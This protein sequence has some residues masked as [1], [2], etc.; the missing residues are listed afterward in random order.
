MPDIGPT[1]ASSRSSAR[2]ALADH[3]SQAE[4][5]A[6]SAA[7][8]AGEA[9]GCAMSDAVVGLVGALVG[10][11]AAVGGAVVQARATERSERQRRESAERDARED[12]E[13]REAES[14][15]ALASGTCSS[16]GTP[17]TLSMRVSRTGR[18]AGVQASPKAATRVTGRSPACTRLGEP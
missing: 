18:I 17:L 10:G 11:F 13:R 16:C 7:V 8:R 6:W 15:R 9:Y 3:S 12:A 5:A 2:A 1:A 14:F 4:A